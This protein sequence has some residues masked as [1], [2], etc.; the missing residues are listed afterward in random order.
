[1]MNLLN[2]LIHL[3]NKIVIMTDR[4]MFMSNNL[5]KYCTQNNKINK[6]LIFYLYKTII[7]KPKAPVLVF[8]NLLN[9]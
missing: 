4:V 2:L 3:N 9:E 7:R 1:M 8:N 5:T 6:K